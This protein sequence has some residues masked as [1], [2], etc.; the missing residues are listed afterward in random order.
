MITKPEKLKALL[1]RKTKSNKTYLYSQIIKNER[2]KRHMTLEEMARGY[3]RSVTSV[4]SRR[5]LLNQMNLILR[6]SL[7]RLILIT[8]RLERTY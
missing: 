2:L 8:I 1:R 5:T 6:Q 4:K 3:V 7:K